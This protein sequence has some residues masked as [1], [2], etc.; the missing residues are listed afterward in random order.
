MVIIRIS[1]LT[2]KGVAFCPRS[3]LC[4]LVDTRNKQGIIVS[5]SFNNSWS[6]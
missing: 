3:P 6:S 4:V 5:N 1:I 2:I